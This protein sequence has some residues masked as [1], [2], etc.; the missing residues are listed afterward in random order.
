MRTKTFA[1]LAL[2]LMLLTGCGEEP[3]EEVPYVP[4]HQQQA[5]YQWDGKVINGLTPVSAFEQSGDDLQIFPY[6]D[7]DDYIIMK[8]IFK[9]GNGFWETT[10]APYKETENYVTTKD[11]SLVTMDTGA[12]YAWIDIDDETAYLVSTATLSS[13]Y[14]REVCDQ[15]CQQDT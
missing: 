7:A 6:F 8:R 15:L 13:A 12:T 4:K 11:Y 9:S 2:C 1:A 5:S 14:V 3:V 10:V